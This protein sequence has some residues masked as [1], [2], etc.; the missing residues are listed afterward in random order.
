M[1]GDAAMLLDDATALLA[2]TADSIRDVCADLRP[3]I[4]DYAGLVAALQSYAQQFSA[5]TGIVVELDCPEAPM[6]LAPELESTLFRIVQEALTN[7]AKHAAAA[8][9]C[10][11]L[12]FRDGDICM[13]ITDNGIGFATRAVGED[14]TMPGLGLLSMRERAEFAGGSLSVDSRPGKGTHLR[15]CIPV[16]SE[17]ARGS[18]LRRQAFFH[19]ARTRQPGGVFVDTDIRE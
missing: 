3:P 2:D 8:Q 1:N 12:E 19:P 10:I 6:R 5:R 13:D 7:C 9:V 14:G 11:C 18:E 15:V 4:L 16:A 17:P